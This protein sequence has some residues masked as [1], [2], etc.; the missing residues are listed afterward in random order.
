MQSC[1][2]LIAIGSLTEALPVGQ[3]KQQISYADDAVTVKV[4]D[5]CV[6]LSAWSPCCEQKEQV[7]YAHAAIAIQVA[8]CRVEIKDVDRSG[9]PTLTM[10][11]DKTDTVM[12]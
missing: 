6:A 3:E 10:S 2:S 11:A 9:L 1:A 4:S 12:C 5:A 8:G 7:G